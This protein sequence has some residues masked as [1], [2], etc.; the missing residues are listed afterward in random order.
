[1]AYGILL[2]TAGRGFPGGTGHP[3]M[4]HCRKLVEK[5]QKND[6]TRYTFLYRKRG[7][8]KNTELIG[9]RVFYDRPDDKECCIVVY[10]A[11][12]AAVNEQ[13]P[14]DRLLIQMLGDGWEPLCA[15]LDLPVPDIP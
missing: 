12:G 5:L 10:E 14:A 3:D 6:F 7:N 4:A 11:N 1:M 8:T 2:A 13:V 15:Y 9:H